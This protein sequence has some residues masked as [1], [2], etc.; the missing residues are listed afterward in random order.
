MTTSTIARSLATL[1]AVAACTLAPVAARAQCN[2]Y[3]GGSWHF[4]RKTNTNSE[5]SWTYTDGVGIYE[6]G[7]LRA[8]SGVTTNECEVNKGWLPRAVYDLVDHTHHKTGSAIFG[9]TWQLS[10]N[11]YPCRRTELFI[12]TEETPDNGQNCSYEPQCWNGDNDYK[13]A[14]CIKVSYND[15]SLWDWVYHNRGGYLGPRSVFVW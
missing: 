14:G 13:S 10:D 1:A 9:R 7:P 11:P 4:L 8:G 12:H 6:I 15:M 5:L 3:G 2:G